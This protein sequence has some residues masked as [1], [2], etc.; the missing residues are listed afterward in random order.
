MVNETVTRGWEKRLKLSRLENKSH[1][2]KPTVS[3]VQTKITLY[4][5]TVLQLQ[6]SVE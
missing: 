2:S 4:H 3:Y 1:S 5:I 6:E